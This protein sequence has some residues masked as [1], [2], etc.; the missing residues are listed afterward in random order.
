V[1]RGLGLGFLHLRSEAGVIDRQSQLIRE[2]THRMPL[3]LAPGMTLGWRRADRS[4]P[5]PSCG[6]GELLACTRLRRGSVGSGGHGEVDGPGGD[7]APMEPQQIGDRAREAPKDLLQGPAREQTGRDLV[8]EASFLRAP[9]GPA[10][11]G[12]DQ[13]DHHADDDRDDEEHQQRDEVLT[14]RRAE[15]K[16]WREVVVQSNERQNGRGHPRGEPARERH[17][18]HCQ[19]VREG[20]GRHRHVREQ[21]Q[22][23]RGKR[24]T[25]QGGRGRSGTPNPPG[26]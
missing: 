14:L 18:C 19:H 15:A 12:G 10:A 11:L 20:S 17:R 1:G 7:R 3:F 16:R 24:R 4:H 22:S 9:F 2:E 6:H 26:E 5:S 23:H 25:G 21:Q 8:H 13:R